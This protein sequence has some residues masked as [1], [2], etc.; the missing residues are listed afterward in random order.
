MALRLVYLS[1]R[2][3][4]GWLVLLAR[5]SATNDMELPLLLR[6]EVAVLRRQGSPTPDRLG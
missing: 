3:L 1:F 5:R 4:R 6:H 2:H